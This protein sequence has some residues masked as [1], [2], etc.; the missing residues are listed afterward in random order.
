MDQRKAKLKLNKFQQ[1]QLLLFSYLLPSENVSFVY[2][3][4]TKR[5]YDL[6]SL[7][8][9]SL[10]FRFNEDTRRTGYRDQV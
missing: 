5:A 3:H 4:F 10:L 1:I 7:A 6:M 2:L 9:S 8:S